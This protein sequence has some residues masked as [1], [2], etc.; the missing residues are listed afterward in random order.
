MRASVQSESPDALF[1]ADRGVK[2]QPEK[3]GEQQRRPPQRAR[4]H[5]KLTSTA[6]PFKVG[7]SIALGAAS[8]EGPAPSDTGGSR[9][10]PRPGPRRSR[11]PRSSAC[12]WVS[13]RLL[14][15]EA[16]VSAPRSCPRGVGGEAE[17]ASRCRAPATAT[18]PATMAR[19]VCASGPADF[20]LLVLGPRCAR[21][22]SSAR[23]LASGLLFGPAA[24][25][26]PPPARAA[27]ALGVALP[28]L[29]LLLG[30][31]PASRSMASATR[32]SSVV[33]VWSEFRRTAGSTERLAQLARLIVR[34]GDVVDELRVGPALVGL[35]QRLGGLAVLAR[36][37]EP[38]ALLHERLRTSP[39]LRPAPPGGATQGRQRQKASLMSPSLPGTARTAAGASRKHGAPRLAGGD[40][41]R[42]A[43]AGP[44]AP[45]QAQ[46]GDAAACAAA[47][48]PRAALV[49][50]CSKNS[51][52]RLELRASTR[53]GRCAVASSTCSAAMSRPE[54]SRSPARGTQPSS[55][56]WR[57]DAAVRA[58]DDPLEHAHVLAEAGPE[59]LAV[60][61]LAEP[62]HQED[63]RRVRDAL[64]HVA[65]SAAK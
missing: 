11:C 39:R 17:G 23:R 31:R 5:Q 57:A 46:A 26:S 58:V 32:L 48:A 63:L 34:A 6:A 49:P 65:A 52:W 53:R 43:R 25:R 47:S 37:V 9:P 29:L 7:R 13:A 12:C 8:A 50:S 24:A 40:W 59:E 20:A 21:S 4:A 55:V 16:P 45:A 36:L 42:R 38:L 18:P 1:E 35:L 54:R 19:S 10:P 15:L 51:P 3:S 44:T 30:E 14:V 61:V 60:L 2:L 28:G 56:S 62:V 33:S 41:P 22:S 64:L 27:P